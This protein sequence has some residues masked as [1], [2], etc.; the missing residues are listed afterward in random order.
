MHRHAW[1]LVLAL[2]APACASEVADGVAALR[3]G[4]FL[5]ALE[6]LEVAARHDPRAFFYEGA[7]L[8]RLGRFAEAL[9]RLEA[10]ARH[11]F[12]AP[13]EDFERGWALLG[14]ERWAGALE[15]LTR[16]DA[17]HPGRGQTSEFL[18]RACLA[19]HR[20]E[21]AEAH[22]HEAAR[23]DPRLEALAALYLAELAQRRNDAAGARRQLALIVE[24]A[25]DSPLG[26]LVR[27]QEEPRSVLGEPRQ[28]DLSPWR[29]HA[30]LGVGADS[31]VYL[32]GR[33]V[34]LPLDA[35]RNDLFPV[36]QLSIDTAYDFAAR[37]RDAATVG[38]AFRADLYE[39]SSSANTYDYYMYGDWFH[40]C[41]RADRAAVRASVEHTEI[42]GLTFR[43][44]EALRPAL[45]HRHAGGAE[46]E[47]A[48]TFAHDA[49]NVPLPAP[50]DR[51]A[52]QEG[53][54]VA[55]AFA[56]GH[57]RVRAGAFWLENHAHGTDFDHRAT[58]LFAE[59]AAPLSG[60][61]DLDLAY[62][63]SFDRYDDP[64]SLAGFA[65]ARSDDVQDA[66]LRLAARV[67]DD[68]RAWVR[69][70]VTRDASNVAFYDS[71][72]AVT[73]AGVETRF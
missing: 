29:S 2:A 27:A 46:T 50:Q 39:F 6:V 61:L 57:D 56:L 63:L 60:W 59:L 14:L 51:D 49:F 24:R 69:E 68:A 48:L 26:R 72:R 9:E 1:L 41:G 64:N 22:L 4:Q 55:H 3:A 52:H 16:Y 19:L 13:D 47:L 33:G 43:D 8:N 30:A 37:G 67:T 7:A 31:N 45:V 53:L 17:D 35:G 71:T 40:A 28:R 11:D 15:A 23:R 58:G 44:R 10:A 12:H 32:L 66:H 38:G 20:D 36:Y 25:P 42:S 18:G 62:R 21:E 34:P 5:R 54:E 70:Q 73:S 65:F